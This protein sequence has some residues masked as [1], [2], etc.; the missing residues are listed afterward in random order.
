MKQ[1]A[2]T[3]DEYNA[4]MMGMCH[5]SHKPIHE[6]LVDMLEEAAK[7]KIVPDKSKKT[8][9]TSQISRKINRIAHKDGRR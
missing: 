6:T 4:K 3:R 7:Y 5:T 2:I 9:H 8:S 1:K